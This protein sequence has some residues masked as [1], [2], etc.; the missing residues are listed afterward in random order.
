METCDFA[1]QTCQIDGWFCKPPNVSSF[2]MQDVQ[3]A[4]EVGS[5]FVNS[6][7]TSY[8]IGRFDAYD[9]AML[10]L[11]VLKPLCRT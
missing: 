11:V 7:L 5:R 2:S 9:M 3:H 4:D 8:S 6:I 10:P 1:N